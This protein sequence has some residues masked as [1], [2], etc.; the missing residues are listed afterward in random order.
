M[1]IASGALPS[2]GQM[3]V[4]AGIIGPQIVYVDSTGTHADLV[5]LTREIATNQTWSIPF[6]D[7]ERVLIRALLHLAQ[8]RLDSTNPHD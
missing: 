2:I 4:E 5:V 6:T 7:R 3:L 1:S 8:D